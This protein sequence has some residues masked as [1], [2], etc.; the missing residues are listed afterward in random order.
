MLG[1]NG[2][3]KKVLVLVDSCVG[4][5]QRIKLEIFNFQY[6]SLAKNR[7]HGPVS[8]NSALSLYNEADMRIMGN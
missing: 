7:G 8:Y 6:F 1:D 2:E 5:R 3:L 4:F